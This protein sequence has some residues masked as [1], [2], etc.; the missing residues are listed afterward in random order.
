MITIPSAGVLLV[1]V[2]SAFVLMTCQWII[3][4]MWVRNRP[5]Q[6]PGKGPGRAG[7]EFDQAA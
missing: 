3:S 1:A 2:A 6:E 7:S 4:G 5:R